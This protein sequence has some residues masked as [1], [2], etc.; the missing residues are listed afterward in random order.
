[1]DVSRIVIPVIILLTGVVGLVV[2]FQLK[3]DEQTSQPPGAGVPEVKLATV[4]RHEGPLDIH[5]D[6]QAIPY[7][8]ITLSAEVAGRV[9]KKAPEARAGRFAKQGTVLL[10]IDDRDYLLAVKQLENQLQQ[11]D[12]SVQELDEEIA[13]ALRL[14]ELANEQLELARDDYNRQM[15][16]FRRNV[17]SK[18]ERDQARRDVIDAENAVT[19]VRNQFSLLKTRRSRLEQAQTLTQL[20]LEKTGYDLERTT[21]VAPVDGVIVSDFVERGDYVTMGTPLLTIEDTTAVEVKCNLRMDELYWVWDQVAAG[22]AGALPKQS[23][24][25]Y[26]IP[27]TP[28]TVIYHLEGR[29]YCWDGELW[30]IEGVGLDERT[31]TVP[32]RVIVNKPRQVWSN[33]GHDRSPARGGPPALVR[34]MYVDVVLHVTPTSLLLRVPE[35][36]IRPGGQVWVARPI[37]PEDVR[38]ENGDSVSATHLLKFANVDVVEV[39]GD[40]TVVRAE[41]QDLAE[42][43]S[44]IVSPLAIPA[45]TDDGKPPRVLVREKPKE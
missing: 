36:A 38:D 2:L 39:D 41:A 15:D 4:S 29:D 8:E 20:K 44:V 13:G 9:V 28:A 37:Q 23:G 40:A 12:V 3:K 26:Q 21:I 5:V 14:V 42:G 17:S 24:E 1:M 43:G 25:D 31:R 19:T 6:G 35:M 30:R 11:A 34:G 18:T 16:L 45:S 22:T 32:C 27:R 10:Q 7:Q 33:Q